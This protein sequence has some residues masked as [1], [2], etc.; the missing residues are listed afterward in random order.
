MGEEK[1]EKKKKSILPIIIVIL[2]LVI[3]VGVYFGYTMIY[4][5]DKGQ[6]TQVKYVEKELV[7]KTL[8]LEE[9]LV[10]LSDP[11]GQ[12]YVQTKLTLAYPEDNKK[13]DEEINKNKDRIVDIINLTLRK[14]VEADFQGDKLETNIKKEIKDKINESL[15]EGRV[16]N[17]YVTKF[18]TQ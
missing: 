16:T 13:L 15:V 5:N 9:F 6:K 2:L 7:E 14:K 4:K 8:P 3:G 11:G 10:N 1:K 17:I 18:V 12:K